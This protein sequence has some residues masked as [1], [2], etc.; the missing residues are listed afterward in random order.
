MYELIQAGERTFYIDCPSKMGI[1]RINGDEV[2]LI[3]SGNDKEAGKKA[4]RRI[5]ENGWTLSCIINTHSNADHI[6]GS[7]YLQEKTGCAVY[8]NGLQNAFAR[9]PFLEGAFLFGGLPCKELQ[10][11]FLRAPQ[12]ESRE[13]TPERIPA[14]L[15]LIDLPGHFFDMIGVK[16]PDGV[17]FLADSV[18]GE[19]VLE[20]YHLTFVYDPRAYLETLERIKTL[21]GALFI[22]AHAPVTADI[23]PLADRNRDKTLEI[24]GVLLDVCRGGISNEEALRRVFEHYRLAM[25]FNQYVLV[26][27]TV[28]SYL[29]FLHDDGKLAARFEDNRLVWETL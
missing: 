12:C 2:C 7:R 5:E 17:W 28:R 22:P 18:S 21:E 14:G 27:S 23:G 29:S 24:L 8:G 25:D 11:K 13:L 1:Y 19:T 20:K 10:N 15:E 16:T 4:L 9:Y 6:G 3:D 26:G